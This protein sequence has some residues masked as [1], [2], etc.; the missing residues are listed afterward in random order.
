[1]L[2]STQISSLH[3]L[4]SRRLLHLHDMAASPP[5]TTAAGPGEASFDANV[6]MILAVLLCALI[7]ALGLNSVVRCALRCSNRVA[8][9]SRPHASSARLA[10]TGVKKTAL[11]AFPT[12]SYSAS[13]KLPMRDTKCAIC[14]SEFSNGERVRVLLPCNHGFHVRCIDKWLAS[15][16]SCPTCRQCLLNVCQ[17]MVGCT[18]PS[19]PPPTVQP[20]IV[21]LEPEGL[22]INYSL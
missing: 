17:K 21:P 8:F 11:K 10:N 5:S 4:Y 9:D 3:P 7:C 14:L 2:P 18:A 13:F 1:M 19:D 22:I 6:I 20:V 15:H 16:S 12:F